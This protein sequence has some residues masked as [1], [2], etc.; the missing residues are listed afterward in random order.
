MLVMLVMFDFMFD[1]DDDASDVWCLTFDDDDDDIW[2][3]CH[4]NRSI[5]FS[6]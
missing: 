2:W 5:E 6:K 4:M 3:T 1:D